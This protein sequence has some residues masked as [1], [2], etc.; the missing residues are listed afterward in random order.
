M[1]DQEKRFK[2]MTDAEKAMDMS[3]LAVL[4]AAKIW[5]DNSCEANAQDLK[6][7]VKEWG[8]AS[9]NVLNSQM[10]FEEGACQ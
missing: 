4:D 6:E 2:K 5:A 8:V 10:E 7:A 3:V 9:N 1:S